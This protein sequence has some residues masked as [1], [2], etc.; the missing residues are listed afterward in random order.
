L[1]RGE[2]EL[3]SYESDDLV[4]MLLGAQAARQTNTPIAKSTMPM[5]PQL[6]A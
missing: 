2:R 6:P 3:P 5:P 4:L 1:S